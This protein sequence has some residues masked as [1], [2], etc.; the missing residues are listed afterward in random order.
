MNDKEL[1]A[2][3]EDWFQW[4][5]TR[6]YFVPPGSKNILARMQPTKIRPA[7]D[8]ILSAELSYFNMGIHA[9]ADMGDADADCFVQ[10]YFYRV[11]NIKKVADEMKIGRRTFY[12]RLNRF[13]R[14]AHLLSISLKRAH[15]ESL[16]CDK[17]KEEII[18]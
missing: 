12:D 9:L 18:D 6:R 4:C 14:K 10:Y 16:A 8:A 15:Q 1:H 11:R 13:A 7:P 17:N 2:Y 3:C 5:M